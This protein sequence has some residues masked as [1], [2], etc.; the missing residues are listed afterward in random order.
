MMTKT[1]RP[2]TRG[3]AALVA[4]TGVGA[5]ALFAAPA[6]SLV[7]AGL[8]QSD[9]E[10]TAEEFT[11]FTPPPPPAPE[12]VRMLRFRD[13]SI[14]FAAIAGHD[15]DGIEVVR[16]DTSGRARL[17]WTMLDATQA[18]ELK[19]EFGYVEIEASEVYVT[20]ERLLLEGGGAVTGVIVSR[21]G[22]NFLVKSDG[23]VQAIPKVRV[24]S[25]EDGVQIPALDVYSQEEMYSILVSEADLESP[26]GQVA[27]A[28]RCEGILDF[29]HAVDH[30]AAALELGM[31]GDALSRV[32]GAL[33]RA[34][35]KAAAQEQLE[36]LRTADQE[37]RRGNYDDALAIVTAFPA[38]FP[39]SAL[40]EDA[41]K[42]EAKL[43]EAREAAAIRLVERRW[44]HWA[45]RLTRQKAAED[46][47]F[48]EARTWAV[49]GLPTEIEQRVHEDLT[50][51][52]S[53]A[54]ELSAVR[55]LF[56]LREKRKWTSATYGTSGTWLLGLD[57]AQAGVEQQ[58]SARSADVSVADAE[59]RAIEERIRR[60]VENQRL[61]RQAGG[62]AQ[63]IDE[64]N[65]FWGTWSIAGRSGWL[66]AYYAEEGGD[67]EVREKPSLRACIRC[68]GEGAIQIIAAGSVLNGSSTAIAPCPLCHGVQVVRRIYYR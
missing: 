68:A 59:R 45:K 23:N 60:Y 54:Y 52:V 8:F 42:A 20:G 6:G 11:L 19:T 27:L 36:V 40:I 43:L 65:Q 57:A 10:P 56:E 3:L 14:R 46:V 50:E 2:L 51:D 48:D 49:E 30:Y 4:A 53:V 62:A 33:A 13:G 25:I 5:I 18:D 16:V 17:T 44:K 22:Q 58:D 24:R 34:E 63:A 7:P 37:R 67:F 64:Q 12:D 29:V 26:E 35:V 41:R 38:Q 28:E 47:T 32:E 55:P 61:A 31:E 15:P 9:P 1:Y 39:D 21:E 66:I